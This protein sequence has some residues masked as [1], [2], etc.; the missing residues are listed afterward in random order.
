MRTE[1]KFK[2]DM[3]KVYIAGPITND[4][5]YKIKFDTIANYLTEAGYKVFNPTTSPLGLTYREYIDLGLQMLMNCDWMC[6]L[7]YEENSSSGVMLEK[8]YAELVGM[9]IIELREYIW[10][11]I[12][13]D[14]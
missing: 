1:N 2:K 10:K 8:H 14:T 7:P 4:P 5:N 13:L 6:I 12:K 3:P 9:P 11:H